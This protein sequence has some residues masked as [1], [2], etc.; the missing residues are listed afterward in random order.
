[1]PCEVVTIARPRGSEFCLP[2]QL[3][4]A[5]NSSSSSSRQ[6]VTMRN[7]FGI[8]RWWDGHTSSAA[9]PGKQLTHTVLAFCTVE[10][11]RAQLGTAGLSQGWLGRVWWRCRWRES[12]DQGP[13]V[14]GAP[15]SHLHLQ[16]TTSPVGTSL[17]A[18]VVRIEGRKIRLSSAR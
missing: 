4:M 2:L 13:M 15:T 12:S 17:R 10:G 8:C 6:V 11:T 1:M 16:T 3:P 7:L 18:R 14:K 5:I 9:S